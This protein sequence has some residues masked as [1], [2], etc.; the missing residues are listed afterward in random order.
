MNKRKFAAVTALILSSL[1]IN[2]AFAVKPVYSGGKERAAIRGYDPVA[3][4]TQNMPVKGSQEF[5]FKHNG[6]K[7]FFSSQE[8][9]EKF[10]ANPNSYTPQYGGYCAYA[11]SNGSTASIK[12]ENFTIYNDKLYLNYS[13]SVYKK[14]LK[15]KDDYI[16]EAN[17][18]W[19][20]ILAE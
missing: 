13:K 12:P 4:F 9:L 19:P 18:E 20:Q 5:L 14:W 15:N 2:T 1:A 10:K 16:A 8:N 7:W 17:T 6:A 3:Y 11:V